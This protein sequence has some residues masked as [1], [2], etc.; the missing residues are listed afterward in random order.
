MKTFHLS[1]LAMALCLGLVAPVLAEEVTGSVKSVTNTARSIALEV[2]NKG[3]L[4]FKFDAAT[5]FKNASSEIGRAH[6]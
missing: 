3:V 1:T 2:A 5:Q 4:V 6:V